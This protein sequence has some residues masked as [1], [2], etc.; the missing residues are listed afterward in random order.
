MACPAI[1]FTPWARTEKGASGSGAYNGG[2]AVLEEG[3]FRKLACTDIADQP[4]WVIHADRDGDIWVGTD[5][6]GLLWIH[7]EQMVRFSSRD[8]LYSDQAFQILEDARGRLWMNC[9]KGIYHVAKKDLLAFAAGKSSRIPC[10][11]FGKSEGIKVTESSGPAQPAGCID[12]QGRI[13]FP[14]IR[15]LSMFDPDRQRINHVE[16]PLV[17]EKVVINDRDFARHR[18]R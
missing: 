8:G 15:G 13:W 4:V 17:I 10:V 14:T 16:P 12:R 2:L 7:D 11:S 6:A 1:I 3:R 9:N 18:E 5:H